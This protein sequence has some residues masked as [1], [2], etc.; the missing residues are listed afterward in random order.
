M[1]DSQSRAG[2]GLSSLLF[3]LFTYRIIVTKVYKPRK[4]P[5]IHP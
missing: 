2:I 3:L 1:S 4:P 5:F